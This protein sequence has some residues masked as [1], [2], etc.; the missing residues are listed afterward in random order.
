M[1]K[2]FNVRFTEKLSDLNSVYQD[3]EFKGSRLSLHYNIHVGASVYP[4]ACKDS[5]TTDNESVLEI[6]QLL[7]NKV[8]GHHGVPVGF[9]EVEFDGVGIVV[10]IGS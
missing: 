7:F 2:D 5:S 1:T 8:I 10:G 9:G 6:G 3:F 4:T